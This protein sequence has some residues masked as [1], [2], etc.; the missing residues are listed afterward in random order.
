M[1]VLENTRITKGILREMLGFK[2][3]VISDEGALQF[4]VFHHKAFSTYLEAAK[5]AFDAGVNIENSQEVIRGVYSALPLLVA[6]GIIR[7]YQLEEMNRPL[8]LALTPE[9]GGSR[10]MPYITQLTPS[11]GGVVA[12][13]A[14]PS[15]M[16]ENLPPYSEERQNLTAITNLRVTFTRLNTLGDMNL[17]NSSAIRRN[18][19]FYRHPDYPI[20]HSQTYQPCNC[21]A[22]GS[23][24][25]ENCDQYTNP[26]EGKVAGRCVCKA[27]VGGDKCD[28]C[29]VGYWNFRAD[30][31]DGC[32]ECR[33]HMLGTLENVGCDQVT[34]ACTCKRFVEG[35]FCDRCMPGYF[36]LTASP[37]GF[38]R[39]D[40][41][42]VTVDVKQEGS[43]CR[44]VP[45]RVEITSD[46]RKVVVPT[47]CMTG[48]RKTFVAI[49]PEAREG[50]PYTGIEIGNIIFKL[51]DGEAGSVAEYCESY[52]EL[53][54]QILSGEVDPS[55]MPQRCQ[56]Y[57]SIPESHW[58]EMSALAIPCECNVTGS[59]V[60]NTTVMCVL[61]NT[62]ITKVST[63]SLQWGFCGRCWDSK[64]VIRGVYSALPL[65]VAAGIIRRYQLEEMNR[66]LFLARMRQGEFDP[67]ESNPYASLNKDDFI[68]SPKHRQL[69]LVAGF[70]VYS[71]GSLNISDAILSSQVKSILW[72]GYPGQEAGRVAARMLLGRLPFTWYGSLSNLPA[73][74][75]YE[76]RLS[77]EVAFMAAPSEMHEN[78]PPYSEERQNL[79]AIT[80]LRVTFTRLNTLA[81]LLSAS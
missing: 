54:E 46:T 28:R 67:P 38:R 19:G 51:D 5:A 58:K 41:W 25:H 22:G 8:F 31:P 44:N 50:S 45:T 15:E 56:T 13:M 80:N 71:A 11:E 17:D 77:T 57:F 39:G 61:E 72:F 47:V 35:E 36:N 24:A 81:A 70:F 30:N 29:R 62:R 34:G 69:S 49:M 40:R 76:W 26:A 12:F 73:I 16:H 20:N 43:P 63:A 10:R 27:N 37:Q 2:G 59:R 23:E 55:Q 66:P 32:E 3:F 75:D 4:L 52:R 14:A 33:C 9:D 7:R 60:L 78:L 64:E 48:D 74:T 53:S 6:A 18:V 79:T 42:V 1:C 21:H 65:L 68:Q